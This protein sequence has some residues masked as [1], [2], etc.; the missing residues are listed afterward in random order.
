MIAK[1]DIL[2]GKI[3]LR[4]NYITAE[5]LRRGTA[6]MDKHPDEKFGILLLKMGYLSEQ[7]VREI[8]GIQKKEIEKFKAQRQPSIPEGVGQVPAPAPSPPA[9]VAAAAEQQAPPSLA[10]DEGALKHLYDYLAYARQLGASDFHITIDRPPFVRLHGNFQFM[11]RPPVEAEESE[12]LLLSVLSEEQRR[13]LFEN[14][15]LDFSLDLEG[16]GRYRCCIIRQRLG[17]DGS[18]RVIG[19]KVPTCEELNLPEAVQRLT[20]YPQGMILVT[21][22]SGSGKTTTLAALVQLVNQVRKDHI[23]TVENPI[24]YIHSGINCQITQ[25]G[26]NEHTDSFPASLRAALRE[27]PDIIM[28][29]EMRDLETTSLAISA[30]ET[31]HLVFSSLHTGNAASTIGRIIDAFPPDQ[32][33][34]IRA[35]ISGSLKGIISQQLIPRLDGNGRELALEVLICDSGVSNLIRE[36]KL[37]QIPSAIQTGK[38]LGM[39]L[40]DES[41]MELVKA[42]KVAPQEA[43]KRAV[44][45]EIFASL[46]QN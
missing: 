39:Q 41:L 8:L 12:N 9:P 10:I 32:Q 40:L 38:R 30:S 35:M 43:I 21:G 13:F 14:K 4:H 25:R 29:G 42:K 44:K 46:I 45:K 16:Q 28:I 3:A 26:L 11:K 18:F 17:W 34:Q 15:S 31:G 1:E 5:Q 33:S 23:I 19:N 20:E 24:E 2:F 37:H 36:N 7:Q 6:E 27:D 22:P